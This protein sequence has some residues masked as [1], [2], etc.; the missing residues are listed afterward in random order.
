MGKRFDSL[1][2]P[3][4]KSQAFTLSYDDGVVQDRRLAEIFRK[5]GLKCT[6]NSGSGPLGHKDG[7]S[8]PCNPPLDL[9]KLSLQKENP[10]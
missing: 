5:R 4:G 10:V 7:G 3:G 9:S 8:L 2:F 6:F 1:V